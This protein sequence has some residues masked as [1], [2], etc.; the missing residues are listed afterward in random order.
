[1]L[2]WVPRHILETPARLSRQFLS[3]GDQYLLSYDDFANESTAPG[4]QNRANFVHSTKLPIKIK[5][6]PQ[7]EMLKI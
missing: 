5:K 2:F 3:P 4:L 6:N 7:P 1:M